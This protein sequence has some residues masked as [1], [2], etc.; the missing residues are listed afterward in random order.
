MKYLALYRKY[1]PTNFDEIAGQTELIKVIQ[2]AITNNKIS[3]AYLFSG[4]RGT[5]KTTTAKVIA[6]LVNCEKSSCGKPCGKCDFC[7]NSN[8]NND[9]IEIDAASNNGVEEI[10]DIRD[11]ITLAPNYGKYKVYI[12]DEVHMLTMQAFNALLKT[13]EEPPAH[14]IFILATTEPHKVPLTISSRCQKFNFRKLKVSEIEKRLTL[15]AAKENIKITQSAINEI[16]CI[17]DGGMRDAINLLDQ[18]SVYSVD[19]ITELD[20][21]KITG[22][23]SYSELSDF[24]SYLA[25]SDKSNIIKFIES[26]EDN[27]NNK[28]DK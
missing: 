25:Y 21:D 10:R 2:N 12:I 14:V 23:I 28:E 24:F 22:C 5:G 4:P 11:K 20:V 7:M 18:L 26:L 19:E 8:N 27:N 3:H 17:S 9:I 13:L 6:K 1:R 16:A 15:I